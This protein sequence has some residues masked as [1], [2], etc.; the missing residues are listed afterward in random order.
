MSNKLKLNEIVFIAIMATAM[1][2]VWWAYSFFYNIV[3]PYLKVFGLGGLLEGFW[4][5]GGI[6]FAIIIRKTGSAVIGEVVAAGV[7][8]LISQWGISALIS[9]FC[10]GM[11]VEIVFLL[12]RYKKWDYFTC[13]IAGAMASLGGY[14]VTY[15][16][17]GYS[18]FTITFNITNLIAGMIS[19]AILGGV[20]SRYLALKLA[21]AGVL[22][23]FAI[24]NNRK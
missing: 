23:Q 11:P 19:G 10:Q 16:W 6:F 15:F 14:V 8:G 9:G 24:V 18:E 3:S 17:Y 4:Q 2:I 22:N 12:C 21:N 7:E 1:G 5:M 20:F 13:A